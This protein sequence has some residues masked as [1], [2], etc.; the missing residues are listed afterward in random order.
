MGAGASAMTDQPSGREPE[1]EQRAADGPEDDGPFRWPT[2]DES[3]TD[4]GRT[5]ARGL[6]TVLV[7]RI[8]LV[9]SLLWLVLGAGFL[10]GAWALWSEE[11][12]RR[13]TLATFAG[14]AQGTIEAPF[15]RLDMDPEVLGEDATSWTPAARREACAHLR[16]RP[17]GGEEVV[18]AYCRRFPGGFDSGHALTWEDALGPRPV[19]WVDE[20][21]LPRLELRLSPR[22]AQW[23]EE[24]GPEADVFWI[25]ESFHGPESARRADRLLASVWRAVDD[26][27]LRLLE[28]WSKPVAAVTVAYAPEDPI[29]A[30]PL[31]VLQN[32]F[33]VPTEGAPMAG[34]VLAAILG[35]FGTLCWAA[36]S[37]M[38]TFG[39]RWGTAMLVVGGLLA[40]PWASDHLGKALS[41]LW[42]D[43]DLAL[44]F[45]RSDM[46]DLPPELVLGAAAAEA[47][48]EAEALVWTLETSSYADLLH[49]IELRPPNEVTSADGVLRHL[50]DQVHRQAVALPDHELAILLD[51]AATVQERGNGEELGLLFVDAA[52][53][54]QADPARS[55]E[56][57]W[58]AERLLDAVALHRPSD[59]PHRGAVAERQRILARL[60]GA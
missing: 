21:G 19:R 28:E 14:R 33:T 2:G 34:W 45:I 39:S 1:R 10:M 26:P 22:L 58:E 16:F 37:H 25:A 36:G 11:R 46:L 3:A 56:V 44:A 35:F 49:S 38:A 42:D 40:V 41:F 57:R 12:D 47:D 48:P 20:Q 29:R 9:Q 17:E 15:W 53:E 24:R 6:V 23:L 18:T 43:A 54:L 30:A 4:V 13:E 60:P 8:V 59:N 5:A 50:A 55:D 7:S 27:F 32:Q 51:W 31:P 52:L